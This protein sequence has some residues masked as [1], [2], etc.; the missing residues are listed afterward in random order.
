MKLHFMK[1]RKLSY[2]VSAILLGVTVI[3][4]LFRGLNYGIDFSGGISME[5]TPIEESMTI[6]KMRADL[7]QFNPELQQI[8]GSA[9][10]IRVGLPKGVTDTQQNERVTEI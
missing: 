9:I 3:S 4:L 10:L 5:V 1:Y 8:D 7:A 6:D 2:V